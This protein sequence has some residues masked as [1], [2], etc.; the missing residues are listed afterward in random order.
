MVKLRTIHPFPARMA[1]EIVWRQLPDSRNPI[2]VLDPMAGSGTTI[3]TA[4]L[5]GHNAIGFDRDPL[6]VLIAGAWVSNVNAEILE[7]KGK[8]ILE[9]AKENAFQLTEAEAFPH[10]ANEETQR[11]VEYWFDE[12]NRIQLTALSNTISRLHDSVLKNLM[13]CALSRLIITKKCG[14]SLAMDV[15]HSRPHRTCDVAPVKPFDR[16]IQSLNQIIK[17]SPFKDSEQAKPAA[18]VREA[19]ARFLDL[20]SESVDMAITS[21]PYLNAIDY[22]RGHKLSLV[23]M[24]FSTDTIRQLRSTNVGS[25]IKARAKAEDDLTEKVID[26]ICDVDQLSPR[27]IGMLRQYLRDMKLVLSE[28]YRVLTC[29]GKAVLVVGNCNLEKTFIKNSK[30]IE[31]LAENVGLRKQKSSKRA[32]PENRRYLPPPDSLGAGKQLKKRMR[33]EVILTFLKG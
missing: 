13:W 22:L 33:E 7:K 9:R 31:L 18:S 6:A 20:E 12:T 29:P 3:A 25:E 17:A 32:L 27:A 10:G 11:F 8:E 24:G 5:R 21:P 26:K 16:F 4:R 23:W 1:P 19:D 28:I 30:G 2:R 15:S 14:V